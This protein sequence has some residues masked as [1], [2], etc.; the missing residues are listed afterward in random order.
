LALLLLNDINNFASLG[1]VST[2]AGFPIALY[3]RVSHF[4]THRTDRPY[5]NST[6]YL[7][8]LKDGN[9]MKTKDSQRDYPNFYELALLLADGQSRASE[10]RWES[11]I[12]NLSRI[13]DEFAS[14][15]ASKEKPL[16]VLVRDGSVYPY[17]R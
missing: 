17:R 8:K 3:D 10:S 14:Q 16:P 5:K 9:Q 2:F 1:K 11:F 7:T 13:C 4:A 6:V 15:L 12:D